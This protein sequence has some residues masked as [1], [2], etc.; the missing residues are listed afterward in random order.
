[1][2]KRIEKLLPTVQKPARYTGGELNQVMKDKNAVDIRY[3][4]CFPDSYE[5]GMS[6]L[7]IKILYAIA[8]ERPDTWCERVFA[9]WPDMEEKMREQNI[10]L[11]ALES[12]D[13]IRDFDFIGF[14]LQYELCYTNVLNMLDLAGLPVRAAD[15]KGLAPIVM[16]G[17]PCACNPEPIADFFDLF[18]LGEG[19]E[20]NSE[21]MDLYA[22]HK[23]R[24]STKEA[25]LR[26]A[27]GI[28]GVYVPSLYDISYH[29]DGTVEA[30]TPKD[31]APATVT[32][33]IVRDLDKVYYPKTF[34]VP[35][36]DVV[37]DRVTH[38]IFRGCIRGC[39][40]CQACFLNRPIREKSP[41]V[42]NE[43]CK[44][45]IE[46]TG[47]DEISLCSLSSSDYTKIEE[48]LNLLLDWTPGEQVNVALP[49]L[50]VDNFSD[51]LLQKLKS[52]RRS[53]LTFAPE[54]GTQRMRDVINKNVTE[55]EMLETAN[56]A[57]AGGY[58]AVKLYFMLGLPTETDEDVEGIG[59]LAKKVVDTYYQNPDKPKGRGVNVGVSASSFV[60]KP[61]TPFQWEPQATPEELKHKQQHLKETLPSRKINVS[62]HDIKTS[63]LEGVFARGDRRLCAVIEEAWKRGC[64][65]D[66]WGEFYRF[67]T[68]MEVFSDLGLDP[69]FY[70][71]RRREYGEV[72]PWD[73][74]NYGI[75]KKYLIRE[76]EKA[77]RAETTDNCH[78]KC[79][80][81]GANKLNGGHCD[82]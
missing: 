26:D 55:E 66:S 3:A 73:H 6:H 64:K 10:P 50:R 5:I 15:R 18:S 36:I 30:I 58:S 2:D 61:F 27:A 67:D 40:F 71:N 62:F 68:W 76:S 74:L 56:I 29:E 20:V 39:R 77:K 21:I 42:I 8:N 81:C 34:V 47:Y 82:V 35:F 54:A 49:S 25:F 13:P 41:E 16:G 79:A 72:L 32:K 23:K 31:G 60:P 51:E 28:P 17:G 9:P 33:R 69:A 65:F 38:E 11:Y 80:G 46:Q 63:F 1:M 57:F 19:E 53:G 4:F 78:N 59:L 22:V 44:G 48:L 12:G 7:G 70:A 52:V 37:H 45:L 43:Q 14:T 75:P 24:G